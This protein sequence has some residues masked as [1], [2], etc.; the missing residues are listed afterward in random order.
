[1]TSHAA[2]VLS[3]MRH[4][5]QRLIALD[6]DQPD[7]SGED[8]AFYRPAKVGA[9]EMAV[10]P[11]LFDINLRRSVRNYQGFRGA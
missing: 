6:H 4:Q 7:R 5:D 8:R 9:T 3:I 1:M 10:N 2:T 11:E